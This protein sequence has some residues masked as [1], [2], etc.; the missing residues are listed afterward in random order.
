VAHKQDVGVAHKVAAIGVI[1]IADGMDIAGDEFSPL[2]GY[3]KEGT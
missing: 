2:Q 3:I 1:Q